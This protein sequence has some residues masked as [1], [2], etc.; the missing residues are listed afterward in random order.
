MKAELFYDL[1]KLNQWLAINKDTFLGF[2][3]I[4]VKIAIDQGKQHFMVLYNGD[5][6]DV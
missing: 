3:V 4:D 5:A 1:N 2:E 6:K